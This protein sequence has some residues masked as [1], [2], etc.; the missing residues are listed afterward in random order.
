[1]KQKL[2]RLYII[3]LDV[4]VIVRECIKNDSYIQYVDHTNH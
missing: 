4:T 3:I 1:M 2:Y